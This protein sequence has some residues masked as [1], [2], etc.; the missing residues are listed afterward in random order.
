MKQF[1]FLLLLLIA[2]S[3]SMAQNNTKPFKPEEIK[4]GE[5]TIRLMP[6]PGNTFLYDILKGEQVILHQSFHP[7]NGP[8]KMQGFKEKA[9]AIKLARWQVTETKRTGKMPAPFVEKKTAR[10]LNISL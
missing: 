3:M 7:V 9:D 5:Y 1:S 8:G 2:G 6:A 4:E 10:E